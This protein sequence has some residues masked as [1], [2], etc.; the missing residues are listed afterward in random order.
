VNGPKWWIIL[1]AV[2]AFI[3]GAALGARLNLFDV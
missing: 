1:A 3:A 2:A